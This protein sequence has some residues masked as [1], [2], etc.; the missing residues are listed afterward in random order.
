MYLSEMQPEKCRIELFFWDDTDLVARAIFK[1]N[2]RNISPRIMHKFSLKN[3]KRNFN[4]KKKKK[5]KPKKYNP[6]L[7]K[8]KLILILFI[9]FIIFLCCKAGLITAIESTVGNLI[10]ALIIFLLRG[11]NS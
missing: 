2:L 6:K 9:V 1:K 4:R 5:A 10:A 8:H 7:I 3:R 11:S